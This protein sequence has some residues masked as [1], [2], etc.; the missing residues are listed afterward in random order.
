MARA[1]TARYGA[2]ALSVRQGGIIR[3]PPGW[4]KPKKPW[5]LSVEDPQVQDCLVSKTCKRDRPCI[6]LL[7]ISLPV[8][9]DKT[10]PLLQVALAG[11][12]VKAI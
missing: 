2:E 3:K 5:L 6:R 8:H 12:D 1:P 11:H 4:R 10:L 9:S 7:Q